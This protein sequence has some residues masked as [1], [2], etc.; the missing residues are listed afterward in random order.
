MKNIFFLLLFF[1]FTEPAH[2]LSLIPTKDADGL[3]EKFEQG[4]FELYDIPLYIK[5]LTDQTIG[6]AGILAIIFV[7][8]G[9]YLYLIGSFNDSLDEGKRTLINVVWGLAIV[10]FAWM[11]IDLAI[12]IMTEG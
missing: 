8:W 10:S 12:R 5:Y 3:V 6:V 7:M 2:A 9:G 11:V 4:T 1:L